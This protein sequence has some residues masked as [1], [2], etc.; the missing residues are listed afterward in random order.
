MRGIGVT[1]EKRE[2]MLD[3]L[4]QTKPDSLSGLANEGKAGGEIVLSQ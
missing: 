1:F 3:K 4:Y 2:S